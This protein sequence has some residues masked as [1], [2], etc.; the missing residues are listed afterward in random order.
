M[1]QL[2]LRITIIK[3]LAGL[4]K[5]RKDTRKYLSAVIKYNKAEIKN[6]LRFSINWML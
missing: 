4:E 6:A 3:L 1:S 5:C 2:E